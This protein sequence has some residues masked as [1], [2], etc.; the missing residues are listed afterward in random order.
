MQQV[1]KEGFSQSRLVAMCLVPNDLQPSVAMANT[2]I[3][4]HTIGQQTDLPQMLRSSLP[5]ASNM[6]PL[7]LH[8]KC[9]VCLL[10]DDI[11][12]DMEKELINLLSCTHLNKCS[13][14]VFT[15]GVPSTSCN[16]F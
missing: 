11:L 14:L 13:P 1:L 9:Q 16:I 8:D 6:T 2:L 15:T 7:S 12:H 5:L 4:L 10:S 3:M